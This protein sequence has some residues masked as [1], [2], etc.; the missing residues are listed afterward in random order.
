MIIIFPNVIFSNVRVRDL[1]GWSLYFEVHEI[2]RVDLAQT[3]GK[4]SLRVPPASKIE[5]PKV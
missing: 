1:R 4:A 3:H 2:Y 5:I